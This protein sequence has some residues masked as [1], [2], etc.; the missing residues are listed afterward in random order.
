M[1]RP[2]PSPRRA[3]D[4][5]YALALVAADALVCAAAVLAAYWL[6]CRIAEPFLAPMGHPITVYLPAIPWVIG[7]W[8]ITFHGFDLHQM[9]RFISP[10]GEMTAVFRAVTL[11]ALMVA[12]ASFLS[13][14]DYSRA[15]LFLFWG[16]ALPLSLASRALLRQAALKLRL[17]GE[18]RA[19]AVVV[20]CGE[21]ARL[22]AHRVR[23][24]HALGYELVGFAAVH[25]CPADVEGYPVLGRLEDL[26]AVIREHRID[27]VL[28]ARPDIDPGALMAA[29]E[30]C[31]GLVVEFHLVAGPLQVLTEHAELS[32]LA[33]L[34]VIELPT[35][36]FP[37]RQYAV[38]RLLDVIASLLLIIPL[39]PLMLVIALLVR[40]ETG[41][42]PFFRQTRVGHRS[43]PFTMYK[44]RTMLPE[45]EPYA[46]APRRL[47]DE[48][49]TRTGRWLRRSS[50][51]EL[52]Q[53][54]NVLKGDM[55]LVGPRPEMPYIVEE[56]EPWQ[57]RR[58]DVKPGITGLWQVLGRKDL[59][60][61]E[62]LQYDFY[63]IRNWSIWLDLTIILK[64]IPVVIGGRGAY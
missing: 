60:L 9:R 12:A 28:V 42:A 56:Y 21:L 22:V 53:L 55:S 57:R 10:V 47:E 37:R 30:A 32:G 52:P 1:S 64:T 7:L 41:A 13:R 54:F 58:L 19:R 39:A 24:H 51:D 5:R 23:D 4:E 59:P 49:I 63:Y 40:R 11:T 29:V 27:E 17:R 34:P 15:M 50:L 16:C 14:T 2:I 44:F 35:R 20:G 18:G 45:A 26:P 38:K 43:A 48:R 46:D 62:N 31:E 25:D 3:F 33:D 61:R 6:R 8:L 36:P